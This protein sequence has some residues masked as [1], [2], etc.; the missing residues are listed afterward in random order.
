VLERTKVTLQLVPG[1]SHE[2]ELTEAEEVLPPMLKFT[3]AP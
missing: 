3:R 1:L 2:R